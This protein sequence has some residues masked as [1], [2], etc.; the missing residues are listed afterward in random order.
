MIPISLGLQLKLCEQRKLLCTIWCHLY[1]PILNHRADK[2]ERIGKSWGLAF[3]C[4][5]YNQKNIK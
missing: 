4:E 5:K 1:F 2:V 3:Q